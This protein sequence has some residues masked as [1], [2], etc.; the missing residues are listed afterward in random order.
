MSFNEQ[1][2]LKIEKAI[3][4]NEKVKKSVNES[5]L[6]L[7][8][9][10]NLIKDLN[11]DEKI[12]RLKFLLNKSTAN[13]H[14]ALEHGASNYDDEEWATASVPESWLHELLNGTPEGI[15]KVEK[16]IFRLS[17]GET[18]HDTSNSQNNEEIS[19]FSRLLNNI[20]SDFLTILSIIVGL[21]IINYLFNLNLGSFPFFMLGLFL[22]F[23]VLNSFYLNSS[24]NLYN[25]FIYGIGMI[26]SISIILTDKISNAGV[27]FAYGL[28]IYTTYVTINSIINYIKSKKNEANHGYAKDDVFID[29][30]KEEVIEK[31]EEMNLRA[32][33]KDDF[34]ID[35]PISGGTGNSIDNPIIIHKAIPNDYVGVEY[36][37]IKCIG[38]G[39][40]IQWK[41]IGQALMT[42]NNKS[43]DQIKIEVTEKT[44]TEIVT[45]IE[46]YYF[47]ITQCMGE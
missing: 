44:E 17:N 40:R 19:F 43:I 42:H 11:D 26:F 9:K 25:A 7:K 12:L 47:D 31:E 41:T 20:K 36:D 21:F 16:I 32:L 4:K 18:M 8:I 33:L 30:K 45:T 29:E 15:K 22:H 28:A 35:F 34:G 6:A 1:E 3:S 46:N 23:Q 10:L 2:L 38:I 27:Y 37:I 13:R 5:I 24:K 14:I 39:R